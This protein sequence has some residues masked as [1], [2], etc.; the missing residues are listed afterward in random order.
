MAGIGTAARNWEEEEKKKEQG[1]GTAAYHVPAQGIGTAAS[2][3]ANQ[4]IGTA[5]Y[6]EPAQGIGTPAS[7]NLNQAAGQPINVMEG[8]TDAT[9]QKLG[10]AQAGYQQ[11][12]AAQQAQAALQQLQ[13]QKPQGY[14]SKYGAQLEGILQ[15][16]QGKKF[17]YSLNGDAFFNA[18]KDSKM[19]AAK[20]ASLDAMGQAA[21]LTGGYGNSAAQ[22]AANQVYQQNLLSLNDDAMDAYR[23]ALQQFQMEQQGMGDQFGRLL[24]MENADYGKYRD[25]VSD[26]NTERGYLTDLYNTEEERGY[27]RYM[28]DLDYYTKLAQ[29]ENADYRSEQERQEAIRQFQM[30]Y[31][32]DQAK[33]NWQKDVD[34]RDYDRGVLES[35]R[36]YALQQQQLQE[37]IR[38]FEASLDWDKMSAQQKYAADYAIAILQNGQMPSEELLQAAGLSADDAALMKARISGGGGGSGTTYYADADGNYYKLENGRYV[39][40]DAPKVPKNA[41]VDDRSMAIAVQG[42]GD[43]LG[44][45]YNG[46]SNLLGGLFGG[47]TGTQQPAASTYTPN[48]NIKEEDKLKFKNGG[49]TRGS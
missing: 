24:Q 33:F 30:Q 17:N 41:R 47:N 6:H 43:I 19:Q 44:G 10:Q 40:V 8:V 35:D 46:A 13:A 18:L 4:G 32:A 31:E 45:L 29:I 42:A 16:L 7:N 48:K 27:N 38:Q 12:S 22:L 2:K 11:T 39:A 9:R 23:L 26:F 34:Q 37:Q 15:E 14:T 28:N 1:I 21:G 25:T 49:N 20:Q 36:N 3:N 5:A